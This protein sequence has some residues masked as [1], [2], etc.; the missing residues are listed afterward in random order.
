[1]GLPN[2]ELLI[3]DC[4][5]KWVRPLISK[6]INRQRLKLVWYIWGYYPLLSIKNLTFINKL[7]LLRR[8][9]N[10]DWHVLHAHKPFEIAKA[11]EALAE[12][13][14][15]P[16]EILIEAGC[17]QGGASTK[18]SIISKIL[19]YHLHI[20]DSFEGVECVGAEGQ[21]EY[22]FSGE[23][24]AAVTILRNNL[25]K[26]GVEKICTIHKGWFVDTLAT[27]P[28]HKVRLAFIDCDLAKGTKE[29]LSGIIPALSKD[30]WIFSQDFH[31]KPVRELLFDPGTWTDLGKSFPIINRLD[32]KLASIR[33]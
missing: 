1:M 19:G 17:W 21:G 18:F 11:C 10:I 16:D 4:Y 28:Q 9:I 5:I 6:D 31:I 30:G 13:S 8:F 33:F 27:P 12:R 7:I 25:I 15:L 24:K 20:Y 2:I 26:Y 3:R 29:V 14:A 23:Y 22:D 32:K